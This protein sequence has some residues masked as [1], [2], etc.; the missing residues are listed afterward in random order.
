MASPRGILGLQFGAFGAPRR[1]DPIEL[2]N[3]HPVPF[4][5]RNDTGDA[6]VDGYTVLSRANRKYQGDPPEV[7]GAYGPSGMGPDESFE[8]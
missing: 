8:Q 3:P 2:A 4:E 7:N 6:G 1:N 5:D